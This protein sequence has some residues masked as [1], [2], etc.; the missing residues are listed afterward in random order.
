[1]FARAL[2]LYIVAILVLVL[3]I[4]LAI[5]WATMPANAHEWYT[6]EHNE[7][8]QACCGGRDCAA[9]PDTAV[10]PVPGG[11][12]VHIPEGFIPGWPAINTFVSNVRAKPA[13]TNGDYHLCYWGDEVR[14][15][16]FPA[17]SF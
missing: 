11:Y 6:A 3:F 14:C 4:G 10:T 5:Q 13:P 7:K 16:F 1:M 17:P 12:N 8:G 9:I 15:F 2:I